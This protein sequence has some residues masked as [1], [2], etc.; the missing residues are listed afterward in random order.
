VEVLENEH[1]RRRQLLDD[2]ARD[3]AWV[4]AGAQDLCQA[5]AR[6]RG[7]VDERPSG[8]GV[9]RFSQEPWT[10]RTDVRSP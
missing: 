4:A 10:T 9:A 2:R 6:L 1:G 8:I 7:N 3:C 5:T